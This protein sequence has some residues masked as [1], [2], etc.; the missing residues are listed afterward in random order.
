M[1]P[2]QGH[3]FSSHQRAL[4]ATHLLSLLRLSAD[5]FVQQYFLCMKT[6]I[7]SSLLL[8]QQEPILMLK[9]GLP[10]LPGLDIFA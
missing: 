1:T 2:A 6:Q 10:Q 3:V 4:P 9:E 8:S 7:L 5:L